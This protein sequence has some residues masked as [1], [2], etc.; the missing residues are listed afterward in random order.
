MRLGL[1]SYAFAWA[2]GLPGH[3]PDQPMTPLHFLAEAARLQVRCMQLCD[4]LPLTALL[5]EALDAFE[6]RSRELG[7]HV[8]VG[9]RGLNPENLR[10]HLALARRF[11]SSFVRLV[12][13]MGF[14]IEGRPAGQGLLNIPWLLGVLRAEERDLDMFLETWPP[15]EPTLAETLAKER[16]WAQESVAHLRTLMEA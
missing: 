10:A 6:G 9:T 14:V 1:S 16:R 4:N 8:E 11:Q 7:T 13:R 3:A 15:P 5:P 12:N 2:I